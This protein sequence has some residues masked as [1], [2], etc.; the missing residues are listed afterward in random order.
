MQ[1]QNTEGAPTPPGKTEKTVFKNVCVNIPRFF[2]EILQLILAGKHRFKKSP[3]Y[4][5]H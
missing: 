4:Y 1:D 2:V 5:G 3:T